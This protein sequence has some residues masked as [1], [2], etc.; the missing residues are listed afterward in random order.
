MVY[1]M[2]CLIKI[3][4]ILSLFFSLSGCDEQ[5]S[6]SY[7]MKHPAFTHKEALRCE[8]LPAKSKNQASQCVSIQ[9][10]AANLFAILKEQQRDPEGFGQM[11]LEAEIAYDEM[12]HQVQQA[13]ATI[14]SMASKGMNQEEIKVQ[15]DKLKQLENLVRMQDEKI[16]ILLAVIG[17]GSPE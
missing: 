10:A 8:S 3:L 11:L 16:Q 14:Q 2:S 12:Q 7:L 6:F 1:M 9:E 17:I 15:Q 5:P 4:T 13:K